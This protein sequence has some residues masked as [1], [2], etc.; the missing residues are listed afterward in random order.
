IEQRTR[1]QRQDTSTRHTR[2]ARDGEEFAVSSNGGNWLTAWHPPDSVPVGTPHG[3]NGLCL[4]G[5]TV[6]LISNDGERWGWPGGRPEGHES[7]ED[8]LRREITEETCSV[9]APAFSVSAAVCALAAQ[10][11]VSSWSAPSGGRKST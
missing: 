8:M 9:A 4:A 10:R 11:R 3:A 2:V 5:D 7:W 6:V 1:E